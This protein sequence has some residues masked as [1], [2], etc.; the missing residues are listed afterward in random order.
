MSSQMNVRSKKWKLA[1]WKFYDSLYIWRDERRKIFCRPK[2]DEEVKKM[3]T[4]HASHV[5]DWGETRRGEIL[6]LLEQ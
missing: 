4:M 6:Y 3:K 5:P 1:E 2:K